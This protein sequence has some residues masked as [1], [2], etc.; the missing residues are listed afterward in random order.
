MFCPELQVGRNPRLWVCPVHRVAS[1]SVSVNPPDTAVRCTVSLGQQRQDPTLF[2][3]APTFSSI[4]LQ[5]KQTQIRTFPPTST[6]LSLTPCRAKL[7]RRAFRGSYF[8]FN[9]QQSGLAQ[10]PPV[11]ILLR[12]G[13]P[14]MPLKWM[15]ILPS[16]SAACMSRTTPSLMKNPYAL[17]PQ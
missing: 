3:V 8:L 1:P 7:S 12:R 16:F 17:R 15:G 10:L 11:L 6:A 2:G 13:R 4:L 5:Q 9:P 14:P